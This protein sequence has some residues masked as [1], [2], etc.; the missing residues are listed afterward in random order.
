MNDQAFRRM[1]IVQWGES[2]G[3]RERKKFKELIFLIFK[4][5]P[6]EKPQQ[7]YIRNFLLI[8]KKQVLRKI[9]LNTTTYITP[10]LIELSK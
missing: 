3:R 7:I 6:H 5:P 2:E 4:K 10:S 1:K 9:P 8:I